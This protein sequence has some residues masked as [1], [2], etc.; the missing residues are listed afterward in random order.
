MA[1]HNTLGCIECDII[2]EERVFDYSINNYNHPLCR[3]CQDWFCDILEYSTATDEAI[4]LYFALKRRGVPALIEKHD[5]FKTIDIAVPDAKVN[6]EVDGTH[7]N[8][9][10]QQA[11]SDLNRTLYS[12]KK[13][14]FTLRIPNSLVRFHLEDTADKITEFLV[15]SKSR[16]SRSYKN[17]RY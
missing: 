1:K 3:N 6:I 16:Q 2:I 9:N 12:F 8:F 17:Y 11:F 7:H 10:S 13:G 4:E 15:V 5:G 14:F